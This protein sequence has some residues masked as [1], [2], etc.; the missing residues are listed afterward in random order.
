MPLP[1]SLFYLIALLKQVCDK[2]DYFPTK[3]LLVGYIVWLCIPRIYAF[4]VHV[5]ICVSMYVCISLCMSIYTYIV[6]VVYVES[7]ALTYLYRCMESPHYNASDAMKKKFNPTND[8]PLF[9]INLP[10][11]SAK[12]YGHT[13]HI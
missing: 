8:Y 5:C 3:G 12:I 10:R 2:D 13:T 6:Y 4:C 9:H 7:P 11:L 1:V